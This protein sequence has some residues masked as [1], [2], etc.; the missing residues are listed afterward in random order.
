MKGFEPIMESIFGPEGFFPEISLQN[1]FE[2]IDENI[3]TRVRDFA[4]AQLEHWTAP[5]EEEDSS[6]QIFKKKDKL[7][8]KVKRQSIIDIP[9]VMITITVTL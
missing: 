5:A 6:N 1:L 9:E 8:K 4:E 3:L 2:N 7:R